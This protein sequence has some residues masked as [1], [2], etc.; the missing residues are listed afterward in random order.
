[1]SLHS[2]VLTTPGQTAFTRIGASSTAKARVSASIAPQMLA[3]SVQPFCG[4]KPATPLVKVIDPPGL[5]WG[6]PYFT[7]MNAPQKRMLTKPRA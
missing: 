5:I 6:L 2:S 3:A 7:A 4:R 1:M